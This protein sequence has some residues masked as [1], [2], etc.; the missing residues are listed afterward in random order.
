MAAYKHLYSK[1]AAILVTM[2][3]V[4]HFTLAPFLYTLYDEQTMGEKI[5]T[6]Q[7]SGKEVAIYPTRLA[8]Q[9]QFADKLGKPLRAKN[10]MEEIILWAQG[11]MGQYVLLLLDKTTYPFFSTIGTVQPFSNRWLLFRPTAGIFADYQH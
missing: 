11:N 1:T 9:F 3:I 4:F 10:T 8:D 6:A 5:H 2:L 7:I